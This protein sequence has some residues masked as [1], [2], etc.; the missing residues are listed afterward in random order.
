MQENGLYYLYNSNIPTIKLKKADMDLVASIPNSVA[1]DSKF[2]NTCLT[3]LQTK[4]ERIQ[5]GVSLGIKRKIVR[6][7]IN[8]KKTD[9]SRKI[10]I[11]LWYD[12]LIIIFIIINQ[13][14]LND[15][16]YILYFFFLLHCI[17]GRTRKIIQRLRKRRKENL[18]QSSKC[19]RGVKL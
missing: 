13:N 14:V 7:Q 4:E 6:W 11:L 5:H 3:I 15:N 19:P 10:Y 8:K 2:E 1:K 16:F 18:V 12:T 9:D 17:V